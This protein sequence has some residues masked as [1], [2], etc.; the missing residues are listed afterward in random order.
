MLKGSMVQDTLKVSGAQVSPVEIENCL[1]AHPEKL[2]V[3]ATVAGVSGGRTADERVPRA[4]VVLSAKGK[5]LG[6]KAAVQ[7]LQEWTEANLS[8][9]KR[10][11]GGVEI[12]KEVCLTSLKS[13]MFV[14]TLF[15]ET[16]P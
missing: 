15:H 16:D 2:I 9:Y 6:S 1:L 11:R 3:D 5:K 12:V 4:W 13:K 10:L 8:K 14:L 7:K